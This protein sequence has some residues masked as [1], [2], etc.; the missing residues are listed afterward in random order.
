VATTKHCPGFSPTTPPEPGE[1]RQAPHEVAANL[2]HFASN[3]GNKDGLAT[4]CKPCG[5]AYGK[6]WAAAKRKGEAFSTRQPKAEPIAVTVPDISDPSIP[7][8]EL[9]MKAPPPTLAVAGVAAPTVYH[10]DLAVRAARGKAHGYVTEEV[11]GVVYALPSGNGAVR[12]DEGQ[13]ALEALNDARATERRRRDAERKR[14]ERAAAKARA[15][16]ARA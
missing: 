7:D 6:A 8:E 14:A 9:A 15:G 13:A 11:N 5:N 3:R 12:S 4:R 16:E 10:D 2:E 1:Y